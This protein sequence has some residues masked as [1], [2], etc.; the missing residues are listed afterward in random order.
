MYPPGIPLDRPSN[1]RL[2]SDGTGEVRIVTEEIGRL[3][4]PAGGAPG[5]W[6]PGT[7]GEIRPIDQPQPVEALGLKALGSN[8]LQ[9]HVVFELHPAGKAVLA[10]DA[11]LH[12]VQP[13]LLR[14]QGGVGLATGG[15][16]GVAQPF[17]GGNVLMAILAQQ[18]LRL[19]AQM[20]YVGPLGEWFHGQTSMP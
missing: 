1:R 8:A 13:K 14:D 7:P 16:E 19:L 4:G 20:F 15:G 17:E 6:A 3:G 11:R 10:G 2:I 9:F 5:P 12:V 18:I